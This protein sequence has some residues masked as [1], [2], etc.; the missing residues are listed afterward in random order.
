M[1]ENEQQ[2]RE[3]L[4]LC[5]TGRLDDIRKWIE[6]GKSLEVRSPR[7]RRTLLHLAVETGFYSLVELIAKAEHADSLNSCI[8]GLG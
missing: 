6:A 2:T 1:T 5:R 7:E 3:L 8:G 4:V